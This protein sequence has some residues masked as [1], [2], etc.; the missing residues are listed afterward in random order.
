MQEP[1]KQIIE[2]LSELIEGNVLR[3]LHR[4]ENKLPST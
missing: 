2:K 1:P 4:Y 3:A